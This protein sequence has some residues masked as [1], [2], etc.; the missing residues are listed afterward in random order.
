MHSRGTT[1]T[2][3]CGEPTSNK[4]RTLK[5]QQPRHVVWSPRTQDVF[6]FKCAILFKATLVAASVHRLSLIAWCTN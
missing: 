5:E 3:S 4:D 1:Y 6:V 2:D